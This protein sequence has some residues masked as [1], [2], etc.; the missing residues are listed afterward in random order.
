MKENHNSIKHVMVVFL[1]LLV[2]LITYIAYFQVFKAPEIAAKPG[3]KRLWAKRNEVLR[4]TIYDR[5]GNALTVS[6]R[7]STLTQKRIY[8][9]GELYSNVLGYVSPKYSLSGLE[10]SFDTEL[11]TY[12]AFSNSIKNFMKDFSVENLKESFKNRDDEKNKIGNSLKTTLDTEVQRVAFDAL[13]NRKGAV[14]A[15]NPKTGEVLAMVSK[16]SFDPNNLDEAIKIANAGSGDDSPLI[17]RAIHGL[18]PPGSTFK[19]ITTAS[20][21]QNLNGVTSRI[22]ND[23]GKIK[24]Q[25]GSSLSNSGGAVYGNI[26]LKKSFMVSSNVVFGTLAME[27][28][29]EK[30]KKTAEDFGFNQTIPS[31]GFA[32]TKSRFPQLKDYEVGNIAQS[33]IG[34]SSI[35]ATPM[36]MALVASAIANNGV[37]MQPK[38]VNEVID[39][40]GNIVKKIGEK[41]YTKAISKD[42]ANIIKDYMKSLVDSKVN[43]GWSFFKGTNAAGKT[44]TADYNLPNG[45]PAKPHS[46][47]IG[48]APADNPRVAVAVIVENGGFGSEAAAPVAGKVISTALKQ[49]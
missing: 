22:F 47:F 24:F 11:T 26:D 7:E 33:G 32:I 44:G 6:E 3:N 40:D 45:E 9:Q 49:Q 41:E 14:V 37:I 23:E 38:L 21:L 19:T 20:A 42:D 39:K 46:W 16:P 10:E 2:G 43:G 48:F 28:G 1:F 30:L 29:N 15:L 34:Q 17:N 31:I 27:L 25:D 8:T 36:Q 35:L 5:D 18:Y 4:G 12:N 13:G